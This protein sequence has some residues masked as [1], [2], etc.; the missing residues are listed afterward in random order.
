MGLNPSHVP[1]RWHGGGCVWGPQQ[2]PG[3]QVSFVPG[4]HSGAPTTSLPPSPEPLL[5]SVPKLI[6]P[7]ARPRSSVGLR[8]L[9]AETGRVMLGS[10]AGEKPVKRH[11]PAA[12]STT[13]ERRKPPMCPST[14][15]PMWGSLPAGYTL[16]P[17]REWSTGSRYNVDEPR[18]RDA[19]GQKPDPKGHI[20]CASVS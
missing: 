16:Q 14:G 11:H 3:S 10:G 9:A 12:P 19:E 7:H 6:F 4:L 2:E 13:A 8:L 15:E 17:R 1:G 18:K 5:S 20:S